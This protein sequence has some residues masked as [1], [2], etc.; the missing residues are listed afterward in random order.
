MSGKQYKKLRRYAK[1]WAKQ[2]MLANILVYQ[3]LPF[4]DRLR[5]SWAILMKRGDGTPKQ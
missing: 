5:I 4:M 3:S 1:H 2:E